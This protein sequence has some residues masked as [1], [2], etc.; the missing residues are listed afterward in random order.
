MLGT[1]FFIMAGSYGFVYLI[2]AIFDSLPDILP[3]NDVINSL[4]PF[5]NDVASFTTVNGYRF[6]LTVAL[7]LLFGIPEVIRLEKMRQKNQVAQS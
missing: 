7:S 4:I 2:H 5:I 1:I 6:E 3:Y